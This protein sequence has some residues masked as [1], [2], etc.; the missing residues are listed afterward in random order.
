MPVSDD[1]LSARLSS[2]LEAAGDVAYSW[3]LEP[4]RLDWSGRL[5]A[6]G[7]DFAAELAT[8]RSFANRVHPDDLVH[9]QLSLAAHFDGSGAFDCEYRLRDGEGGFVWVHERGR[10]RRDGTGRPQQ[11][12]GI[13]RTVGDRN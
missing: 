9:R 2:A 8:G 1:E 5:Y 13:I 10:A 7:I 3:E 6:E 11:M 12:L 4:D